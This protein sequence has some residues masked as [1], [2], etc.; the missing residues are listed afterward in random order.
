M[1]FRKH[2]IRTLDFC[3]SCIWALRGSFMGRNG[4]E[5]LWKQPVILSI[6]VGVWQGL[7]RPSSRQQVAQGKISFGGPCYFVWTMKNYKVYVY[8]LYLWLYKAIF[9]C[10][11]A[12]WQPLN[13]VLQCG[14]DFSAI[15]YTACMTS[16]HKT[17]TFLVNKLSSFFM[18]LCFMPSKFNIPFPF[19][20]GLVYT[21]Y[22][23]EYF[24]FTCLVFD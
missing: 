15:Y 9:C 11:R 5:N 8:L 10:L 4:E 16:I 21:N 18:F 23:D 19:S 20:S 3:I 24:F 17:T 1:N 14:M 6:H 2:R 13:I 7:L 22:R 12:T